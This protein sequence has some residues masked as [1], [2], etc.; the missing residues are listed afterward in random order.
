MRE[1]LLVLP[2]LALQDPTPDEQYEILQT[3]DRVTPVVRVVDAASPAVVYIETEI[4]QRGRHAFLGD[5]ERTFSGSGSGVVVHTE[6]YI[7][8]NYHVVRG[9]NTITVS[10]DHRPTRYPAQMISFVESE[11]L[12]LL[13]IPSDEGP[14]PVVRLGTSSDLM[15]G[16]RVVA[17]GNP[18]GQTH[19]VS[20]GIISGLHRDVQIPEFALDFSDLIQTDASINLGNSGGPLLNIHGELIG[21]NTAMKPRAENIGFAIPV[22]RVREVLNDILF[23]QARRSWLGVDLGEGDDLRVGRVWL[24]GPAARAGICEGDRIVALGDRP[25]GD[26]DDFLLASLEVPPQRP[27]PVEFERAGRREHATI[28]SWDR[29]DGT[30]YEHFGMTVREAA[31]GSGTWLVVDRVR[32]DGPAADLGLRAEDLLPALRPQ[33]PGGGGGAWR[34]DDRRGLALIAERLGAGTEIELDIYRDDD[35]DGAY[36]WND[37]HYRGSLTLE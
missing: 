37:E 27:V 6:G 1:A 28:D 14:F 5:W 20:T 8:T 24:D 9:A 35:G 21:I 19:T 17:I 3:V 12:A 25:L 2:L 7:V 15:P 18:H 29:L 22:D 13:K 23:P 11:D 16:E 32:P 30:L 4:Q 31:I 36:D 33:I 26:L 10:F 34:L